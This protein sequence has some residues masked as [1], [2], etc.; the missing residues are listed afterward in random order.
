MNCHNPK[1]IST[2]SCV[3][4]T[5]SLLLLTAATAIAAPKQ[6]AKNSPKPP[7]R[8]RTE[9]IIP[10]GAGIPTALVPNKPGTTEK[11]TGRLEAVIKE[12]EQ[13]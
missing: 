1:A 13:A 5:L 4:G 7:D 12:Y 6:L 2:L 9:V 3:R 8:R 10:V 11:A